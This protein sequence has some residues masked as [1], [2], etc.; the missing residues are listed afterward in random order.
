M[1]YRNEFVAHMEEVLDVY[2]RPYDPQKPLICLDEKPYMMHADKV[3]PLP[4]QS[5]SP[6]KIDYE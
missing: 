3:Q 1:W 2:S 4:I 5:K 6:R